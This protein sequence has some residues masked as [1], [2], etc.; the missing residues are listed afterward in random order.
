MSAI[1]RTVPTSQRRTAVLATTWPFIEI[2]DRGIPFIKGTR[3]K[4]SEIAASHVAYRWAAEQIQIQLPHLSL[5]QIHAAL[6]YYYEHQEQCDREIAESL[7]KAEEICRQ[8]ENPA[9]LA[10]LRSRIGQ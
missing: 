6:G 7:E 3:I 10:K 1:S 9:L 8:A 5:P 2:D 4:V